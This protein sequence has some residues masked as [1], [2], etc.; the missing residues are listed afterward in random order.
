[1]L[2]GR[3]PICSGSKQDWRILQVRNRVWGLIYTVTM[4]WYTG[5][6]TGSLD[7]ARDSRTEGGACT[8]MPPLK[9]TVSVAAGEL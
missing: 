8:S 4:F 9:L 2:R 5:F 3:L 6:S 1:M 7:S